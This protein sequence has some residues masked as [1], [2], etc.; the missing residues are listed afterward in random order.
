MTPSAR[1]AARLSTV[2]ATEFDC[3]NSNTSRVPATG[4]MAQEPG[5]ATPLGV[6]KIPNSKTSNPNIESCPCHF[7]QTTH[8]GL[9]IAIATSI[10]ANSSHARVGSI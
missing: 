1:I 2:R 4:I 8:Q 7:L 3:P 10:P 6:N 5:H 9:P